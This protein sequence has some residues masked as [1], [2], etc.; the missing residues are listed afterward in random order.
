MINTIQTFIKFIKLAAHSFMVSYGYVYIGIL[1]MEVSELLHVNHTV[2]VHTYDTCL[3]TCVYMYV[4]LSIC[5]QYPYSI[6]NRL[7]INFFMKL[8]LQLTGLF[9]YF[10]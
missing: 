3:S 1:C 6:T 10:T 8:C 5:L 7:T 4:A 9:V 2:S